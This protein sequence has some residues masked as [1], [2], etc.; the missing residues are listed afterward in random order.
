MTVPSLDLFFSL[1]FLSHFWVVSANPTQPT[2]LAML[3]WR[4]VDEISNQQGS[5]R[6]FGPQ[7]EHNRSPCMQMPTMLVLFSNH[8]RVSG[9]TSI[10][11]WIFDTNIQIPLSRLGR[12]Q[13]DPFLLRLRRGLNR[14][15]GSHPV[16]SFGSTTTKSNMATRAR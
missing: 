6:V 8:S 15:G 16:A 9:L 14:N 13:V 5:Q 2:P 3:P 4:R 12:Q 11:A 10:A 7:A 1:C